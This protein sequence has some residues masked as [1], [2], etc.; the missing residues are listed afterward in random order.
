MGAILSATLVSP[1][2]SETAKSVCFWDYPSSFSVIFDGFY[3]LITSQRLDLTLAS[4]M[5]V[6]WFLLLQG[7]VQSSSVPPTRPPTSPPTFVIYTNAVRSIVLKYKYNNYLQMGANEVALLNNN[8]FVDCTKHRWRWQAKVY[9]L[10]V[11]MLWR[12]LVK[13][14]KFGNYFCD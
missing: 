14:V 1:W 2:V 3:P 4:R 11:Q 5:I 6:P 10:T 9:L 12:G 7:R 13:N 8:T